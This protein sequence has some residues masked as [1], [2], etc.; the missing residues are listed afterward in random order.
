MPSRPVSLTVSSAAPP[1]PFSTK[2]PSGPSRRVV[3][4]RGRLPSPRLVVRVA[5]PCRSF[6]QWPRR[7]SKSSSAFGAHHACGAAAAA[8]APPTRPCCFRSPRRSGRS[9]PALRL[10]SYLLLHHFLP[11][12]HLPA[13][14][15]GEREYIGLDDVMVTLIQNC[16]EICWSGQHDA[17]CDSSRSCRC[18]ASSPCR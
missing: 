2:N 12:H 15:P 6:D 3:S 13:W 4:G 16:L 8:L 10:L 7:F 5:R 18:S 14:E 11:R 9:E 1:E 17:T